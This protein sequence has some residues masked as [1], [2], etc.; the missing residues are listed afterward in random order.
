M[1]F[2][3]TDRI[4]SANGWLEVFGSAS[5]RPSEPSSEKE[6]A[7]R[8]KGVAQAAPAGQPEGNAAGTIRTDEARRS[9]EARISH[10]IGSVPIDRAPALRPLF[11]VFLIIGVGHDDALE[12]SLDAIGR[13]TVQMKSGSID[14]ARDILRDA[15]SLL[16]LGIPASDSK[17]PANPLTTPGRPVRPP[18]A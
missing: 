8:L 5:R 18:G 2:P 7:R 9:R 10:A 17:S 14:A 15:L 11:S 16:A 6:I 4:S 13:A 1:T 3:P 12:C